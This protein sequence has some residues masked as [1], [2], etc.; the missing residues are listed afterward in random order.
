MLKNKKI[1][2]I[3]MIIVSGFLTV[4]Y[5]L[6]IME[7]DERIRR[8]I[9]LGVWAITFIAWIFI[10]IKSLMDEKKEKNKTN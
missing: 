8:K 2:S 6:L 3:I 10:L 4:D 1:F 9:A 7:G 5:Y